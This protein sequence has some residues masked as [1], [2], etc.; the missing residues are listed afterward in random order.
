MTT[1]EA[2]RATALL[3]APALVG[4]KEDPA[5]GAL[6]DFNYI[7][8]NDDVC[9][10]ATDAEV[11]TAVVTIATPATTNPNWYAATHFEVCAEEGTQRSTCAPCTTADNPLLGV[12]RAADSI[13]TQARAVDQRHGVPGSVGRLPAPEHAHD[14]GFPQGPRRDLPLEADAL[15]L[16]AVAPGALRLE[17]DLAPGV[18]VLGAVHDPHATLAQGIDQLVGADLLRGFPRAVDGL[19]ALRE[20]TRAWAPAPWAWPSVVP[21]TAHT[22]GRGP[23]WVETMADGGDDA[24]SM[25]RRTG[26]RADPR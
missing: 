19:V 5:A 16:G 4:C 15:P 6:P 13:G 26:T 9:Q 18:D 25:T 12:L 7:P 23:L 10:P 24:A 2:L 1:P 11:A 20:G 8:L 14:A 21:A 3:T 17:G 22:A